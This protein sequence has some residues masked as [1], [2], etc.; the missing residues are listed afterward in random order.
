MDKDTTKSTFN[1]V[2]NRFPYEKFC[3]L[4]KDAGTDRYIKKL[5]SIKLLYIMFIAQIARIESIREM[6]QKVTNNIDLQDTL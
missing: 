3:S 5:F 2:L 1:E 4:I 6:A